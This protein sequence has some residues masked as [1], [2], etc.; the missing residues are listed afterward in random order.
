MLKS[1]RKSIVNK[2]HVYTNEDLPFAL[3]KAII[4]QTIECREPTH[5]CET[6]AAKDADSSRVGL[7]GVTKD[8]AEGFGYKHIDMLDDR[9]CM[10]VGTK[11]FSGILKRIRQEYHSMPYR[12]WYLLALACYREGYEKVVKDLKRANNWMGVKINTKLGVQWAE[13]VWKLHLQT[14][15]KKVM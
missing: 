3:L 12:D 2:L 11:H 4:Y 5:H 6:G 14:D 13:D 10:E 7:M 1:S 8:V 9:K 15:G